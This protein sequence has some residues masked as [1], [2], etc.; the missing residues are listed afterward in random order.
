MNLT[1]LYETYQ[2]LEDPNLWQDVYMKF[3]RAWVL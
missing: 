2:A 1:Q 3:Y